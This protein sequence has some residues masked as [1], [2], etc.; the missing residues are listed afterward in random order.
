MSFTGF[1]SAF[2]DRI[3]ESCRRLDDFAQTNKNKAD[4]LVL[5]LKKVEADEQRNIDS[6]LRQLKSLQHE[7]GVAERNNN[8]GGS[9]SAAIGGGVADQRK[10]LEDKQVKLEQEVSILESRNRV[11]KSQLDE[12]LAEEAAVR[13]KADKVRAK[14]EEI[15]MSR[16]VTMEDLT[17]GFLNYRYTGLSFVQG[18]KKGALTFK[19]IKL[20]RED[21]SRPFS[22][23]V[24]M[25]ESSNYQLEDVNPSLDR[26]KTDELIVGLNSDGKNGFNPFVVGMRKMFKQTIQ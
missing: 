2:T 8:G 17:K 4:S 9:S 20:D 12:V 13:K 25:D 26:T 1:T 24:S 10:K 3:E 16:G 22:F 21:Q 23:T 18:T 14:K 7:R 19:F 11:E 6:L 15:E 5:D